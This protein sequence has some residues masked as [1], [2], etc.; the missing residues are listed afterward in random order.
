VRIDGRCSRLA[1]ADLVEVLRLRRPNG[2][3]RLA[4]PRWILY[5]VLEHFAGH[6][7]QVLLVKHQMRDAGVLPPDP[8]A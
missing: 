1:P 7:G 4:S 6:F 8:A 3:L 2:A 5:H